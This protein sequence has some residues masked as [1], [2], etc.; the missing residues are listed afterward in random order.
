[1]V[2]LME[3]IMFDFTLVELGKG[4]YKI[5]GKYFPDDMTVTVKKEG[6]KFRASCNYSKI[7]KGA[8]NPYQAMHLHD[9]EK[10][11]LEDLLMSLSIA[12]TASPEDFHWFDEIRKDYVRSNGVRIPYKVFNGENYE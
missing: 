1:M 11:T 12:G 10:R 3:K 7:I 5:T 8:A 2:A 4:C 6:S 9:T